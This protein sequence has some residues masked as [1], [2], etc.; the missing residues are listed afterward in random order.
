[1]IVRGPRTSVLTNSSLSSPLLQSLSVNF[2]GRGHQARR[3]LHTRVA[4]PPI[5]KPIPF[6]PDVKTFLTVIGRGLSQHADKIESWDTLFRLS[7][8]QLRDLGIEPARS[9]KYLLRW[10]EKFR[11]GEFGVGGDAKFVGEGGAVECRLVDVSP[12]SNKGEAGASLI[13]SPGSRRRVLNV[14]WTD[15]L[16]QLPESSEGAEGKQEV[17][18]GKAEEAEDT[19][20]GVSESDIG[21]LSRSQEKSVS[22]VKPITASTIQRAQPIEGV[23]FRPGYGIFGPYVRVVKGTQGQVGIIEVQEGMW[24][25][26]R[27]RKVDGGERRKA[28]VRFKRRSAER[29]A[30]RS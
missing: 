22:R 25:H 3:S 8:E 29:R 23:S 19:A 9:R 5:P 16:A 17:A 2:V 12:Q 26:R 1:M 24:E 10:R 4:A 27:G 7:S 14:P 15:P 30:A 20:R 18:E 11:H 28:E 6:V 13:A 21:D